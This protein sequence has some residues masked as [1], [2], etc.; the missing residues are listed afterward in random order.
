MTNWFPGPKIL[1]TFGHVSVPYPM[2]ATACAPP[3]FKMCVTPDFFAQYKTSGQIVPSFNGGVAKTTIGHFAI[4]AGTANMSAV[5]G[6]TAVPPGTYKPTDPI[7]LATLR[8]LTPGIVVTS[9]SP[10]FNCAS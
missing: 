5:V 2:A 8:H 6:N 7:G 4:I 1:S 3:A 9:P 10:V